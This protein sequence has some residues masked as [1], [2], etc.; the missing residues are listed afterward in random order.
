MAANPAAPLGTQGLKVARL[1]FGCMS[2]TKTFYGDTGL[3]IEEAKQVVHS[4][5]DHGVRLF[6]TVSNADRRAVALITHDHVQIKSCA[7]GW[8]SYHSMAD[9]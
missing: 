7:D 3:S 6:N 1:G 5:Y 9:E 8:V 2:L 4:A